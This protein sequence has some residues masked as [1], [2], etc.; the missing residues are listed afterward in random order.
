VLGAA[1]VETIPMG[2]L[3]TVLLK[4]RMKVGATRPLVSAKTLPAPCADLA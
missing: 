2:M 3:F 1:F 4:H